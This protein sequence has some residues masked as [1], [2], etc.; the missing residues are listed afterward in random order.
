MEDRIYTK[1]LWHCLMLMSCICMFPLYQ[2]EEF[3]IDDLISHINLVWSLFSELFVYSIQVLMHTLTI[4]LN[5]CIL[6][7]PCV[8]I[9]RMH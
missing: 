9:W 6:C 7:L 4:F 5:D 1:I 3:I 2:L 8:R